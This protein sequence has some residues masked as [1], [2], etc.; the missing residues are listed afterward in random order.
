[1][2]GRGIIFIPSWDPSARLDRVLSHATQAGIGGTCSIRA[3]AVETSRPSKRGLI[4]LL[5]ISPLHAQ[6]PDC[7]F[8]AQEAAHGPMKRP[9]VIRQPSSFQ[10]ANQ[11]AWL[12]LGLLGSSSSRTN[13]PLPA[14]RGLEVAAGSGAGS[15][16]VSPPSAVYER[17]IWLK[18]AS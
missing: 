14:D 1:M 9:Y 10:G 15:C 3:G 2:E 17:N 18:H 8:R 16:Q 6:S 4:N 13:G 7:L 11:S 5:H 12:G